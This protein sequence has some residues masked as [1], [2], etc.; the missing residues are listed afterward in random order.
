M[1]AEGTSALV[2]SIADM[3]ALKEQYPCLRNTR[4]PGEVPG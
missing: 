4:V 3:L 1:D 2:M